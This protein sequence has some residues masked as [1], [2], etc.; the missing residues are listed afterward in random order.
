M[1]GDWEADQTETDDPNGFDPADATAPISP[2]T[3]S[4]PHK[5]TRFI[6]VLSLILAMLTL[7]LCGWIFA[8]FVE[9]DR[10]V[11]H[12][13]YAFALCFGVGLLAYGPLFW[14]AK[15]AGEVLNT[16]P[17]KAHRVVTYIFFIPWLILGGLFM[18]LGG[19]WIFYGLGVVFVAIFYLFWAFRLGKTFTSA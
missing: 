2:E 16:G 5:M 12:L 17:S 10:G 14:T 8:G 18:V 11:I 6:R 1:I 3:V 4:A 9:N 15:M 13:T 7:C 19:P